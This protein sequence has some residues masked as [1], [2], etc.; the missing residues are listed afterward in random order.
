MDIDFLCIPSTF[1]IMMSLKLLLDV[2]LKFPLINISVENQKKNI[3]LCLMLLRI[4]S[5]EIIHM[6][7][8]FLHSF[9]TDKRWHD[10]SR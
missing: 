6:P 2:W 9:S 10:T 5:L 1:Y 8:T 3:I 4:N 7:K